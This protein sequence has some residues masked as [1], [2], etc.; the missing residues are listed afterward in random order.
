MELFLTMKTWLSPD[1]PF[2]PRKCPFFYGWV[3]LALSIIGILMSLPGQ[4]IGVSAFIDYLIDSLHLSRFQLS[5]A[6]ALGTIT[7]SLFLP[8]SGRMFDRLGARLMVML[9]SLLLSA[10]LLYMSQCDRIA[11]FFAF[12]IEGWFAGLAAFITVYLGFFLLRFAGQGMLTLTSRSMLGKWFRQ[13]RGF[14]SGLNGVVVTAV[15]CLSPWLYD[16]IIQRAD[17]RFAW[18]LSSLATL[19]MVFIGW[20]FFRDNP[21]ECGLVMDGT[22]STKADTHNSHEAETLT[23]EEDFTLHEARRTYSFWVFNLGLAAFGLIITGVTFHIVSVGEHMGLNRDESLQIFIPM[24]YV[25]ISANFAFSW[26]SDRVPLKYLLIILQGAMII[27][28]GSIPFITSLTGWVLVIAG[29]GIAGGFFGPMM[30]FVWPHF[31]GRK[32]LGAISSLNLSSNVF[33]SAL[34]PFIFGWSFDWFDS[35]LPGIIACTL[36]PIGLL[37]AAFKADPP[38]KHSHATD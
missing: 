13:K 28:L 2:P 4:T 19:T 16:L 10:I 15:F 29:L 6:Y 3:V 32:H 37:V 23:P 27:G 30:T 14:V 20:L 36:I 31:F 5:I 34:G 7:S 33:G 21:E 12:G 11:Q 22:H 26:L 24:A 18:I 25:T 8:W 1:F 9:S 35:Y 17:W 38:R